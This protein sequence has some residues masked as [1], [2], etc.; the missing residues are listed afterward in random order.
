[1]SVLFLDAN[2]ERFN[3][4]YTGDLLTFICGGWLELALLP[5]LKNLPEA[6]FKLL[7]FI[8]G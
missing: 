6:V 8:L 5:F 2:R 4:I 3:G 7:K 1:L